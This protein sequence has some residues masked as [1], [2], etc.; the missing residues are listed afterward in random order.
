M[1]VLA[2]P[3]TS[4]PYIL[5]TDASDDCT[6]ACLCQEQDIQKGVKSNE[7]NGKPIYHLSHKLTASQINWPTIEKEA[8]A[9]SYALY[10]LN[11]YLHG[12]DFVIRTDHKP[13]RYIIDSP[14]QNKYIQYFLV[15]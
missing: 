15:Y 10:E 11:Q 8:F 9:I 7:P 3:D 6:G 13:L 5:F 4:K 14:V 12:S 2:C 1:K